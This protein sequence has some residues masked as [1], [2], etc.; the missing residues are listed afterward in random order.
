MDRARVYGT[1]WNKP[2]REKQIQYDFI[3]MWNFRNKTDEHMC[4]GEERETNHKRL[5]MI[6]E[7]TEGWWRE[8][9]GR[10]ARWVMDTKE[11]HLWC[12]VLYV[13]DES[14]NSET[15]KKIG[16]LVCWTIL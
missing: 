4:G 3:H 14:L 12:V 8:V 1:K 13:S 15:N 10:W 2:I 7:Q 5:L 11:G 9:D 16:I 6:W